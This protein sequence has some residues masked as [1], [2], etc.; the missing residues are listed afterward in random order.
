MKILFF[1][2]SLLASQSNTETLSCEV[3]PLEN[4]GFVQFSQYNEYVCTNPSDKTDFSII[5]DEEN[6]YNLGDK[7]IV[8]LNK[9]DEVISMKKQ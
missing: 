2:L 1:T 7:L 3:V 5:A 6:E 9:H 8:K 4:Y